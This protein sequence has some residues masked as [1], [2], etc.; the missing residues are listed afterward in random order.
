MSSNEEIFRKA[1]PPYQEALKGSGYQEKIEYEEENTGDRN[2]KKRKRGRNITWFNPPYSANVK[3]N[4]G[5]KFLK[6]VDKHFPKGHKLHKIFNR[7]TVKI[8]YSC[9]KSMD[10]IIRTHNETLIKRSQLPDNN[11]KPKCNCRQKSDCP[12]GGNCLETAI[13]YKATIRHG[14]EER[15]YFGLAGGTF[16]DRYRN[17]VKS[18]KHEKYKNETQL[19]KYIWELKQN[20]IE[21][22]LTW[23]VERKSNLRARK[24]GMC[25][26][27]LEEKY[28]IIQHRDALNKRTELISKCR[29]RTRPTRKPPERGYDP[30][31]RTRSQTGQSA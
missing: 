3:T 29:H 24:S 16:K 5:G 19:S 20:N 10:A 23:A 22:A 13:V 31:H 30:S 14:S 18:L 15:I 4:V 12:L 26:L 1:A 11:P 9:M 6:L 2:T 7:H 28:A 25:N 27:C 21:Y 8:S 17:H